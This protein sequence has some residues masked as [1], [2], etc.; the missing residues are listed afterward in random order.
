MF[1]SVVYLLALSV[2]SYYQYL[3]ANLLIGF[4]VI[5]VISFLTYAIDKYR[6]KKGYWRIKETTLHLMSLVGG[7]PGAAIAQQTLRHKSQKT[8]FRIV[9][10]LTLVVNNS[11]LVWLL[12][13]HG[14]DFLAIF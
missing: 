3:S 11:A 10:W 2:L 13:S 5:N 14:A 6:A 7:W 12:S 1:L 4:I 8:A 9:F